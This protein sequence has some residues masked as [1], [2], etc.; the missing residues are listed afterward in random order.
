MRPCRLNLIHRLVIYVLT[1][2][3]EMHSFILISTF[4]CVHYALIIR[5]AF[6]VDSR[7]KDKPFNTWKCQLL[8]CDPSKKTN[9]KTD[10]LHP[11]FHLLS[12]VC[13]HSQRHTFLH[14]VTEFWVLENQKNF[15]TQRANMREK[16]NKTEKLFCSINVFPSSLLS[17]SCYSITPPHM[18]EFAAPSVLYHY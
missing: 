18:W 15:T 11:L 4:L 12:P 8:T 3:F 1:N 13:E 5:A 14:C 16:Q 17:S 2:G 9:K 10:H 6:F 7:Q